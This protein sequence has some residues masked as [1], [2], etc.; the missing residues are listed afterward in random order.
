MPRKMFGEL[1]LYRILLRQLSATSRPLVG[2]AC[3][4]SSG[5]WHPLGITPQWLRE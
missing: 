5:A 1:G 4:V 2:R 3:A